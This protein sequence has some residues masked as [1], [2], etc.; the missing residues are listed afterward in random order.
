MGSAG[1]GLVILYTIRKQ[2][3]QDMKSKY[4]FVASALVHA[5]IEFL[6]WLDYILHDSG[7]EYSMHTAKPQVQCIQH[8]CVE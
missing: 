5:L 1:L 8:V 4:F 7:Q 2:A 6:P 3:E